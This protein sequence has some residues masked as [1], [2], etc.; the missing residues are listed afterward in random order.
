MSS[1]K[2]LVQEVGGTLNLSIVTI[3]HRAKQWP[4]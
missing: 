2:K 1:Q 4:N 3:F